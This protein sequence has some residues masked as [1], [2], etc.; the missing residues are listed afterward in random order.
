MNAEN[1]SAI[2]LTQVREILSFHLTSKNFLS[3]SEFEGSSTY[4][5]VLQN[6]NQSTISRE[7]KKVKLSV[8]Q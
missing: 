5:S 2:S 7:Q 3:Y 4:V 6:I 1:L 8:N